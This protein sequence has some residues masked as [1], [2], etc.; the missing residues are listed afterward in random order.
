MLNCKSGGL[1]PFP[2]TGCVPN[3]RVMV[4]QNDMRALLHH[5]ERGRRRATR[6]FLMNPRQHRNNQNE[7]PRIVIGSR[8]LIRKSSTDEMR[9]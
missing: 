3:A 1:L 6:N 7:I 4:A 5:N 8:H 2:R 9:V